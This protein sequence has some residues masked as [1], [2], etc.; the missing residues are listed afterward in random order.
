MAGARV[1]SILAVIGAVL[2]P[3]LTFGLSVVSL[4]LLV[5]PWIV[6]FDVSRA[7]VMSAVV[8]TSL[9]ATFAA[10]MV[11]WLIFKSSP[12]A[13]V[14]AG[15]LILTAGLLL[16]SQAREFWQ[17]AATYALLIG[18]GAALAGGLPARTV[19]IRHY[20]ER[21]GA[22][23]G[24]IMLGVALGGALV[25]IGAGVA[26]ARFGWRHALMGASAIVAVVVLPL[27][28]TLLVS[29]KGEASRVQASS[30]AGASGFTAMM[31]FR[32]PAFWLILA[33]ILPIMM[34]LSAVQS[35][36]V[37][38][39]SD[40]GIDLQHAGYL[41]SIVS[42]GAAIGAV[43]LGSLADRVDLR[44]VYTGAAVVVAVSLLSLVGQ[45]N[46]VVF[47]VAMGL[48]G[49]AAGG[50]APMI[51]VLA[52]R[53]FGLEVFPRVLG[54]IAPFL[55]PAVLGSVLAGRIRDLT[56]GYDLVFMIVAVLMAPGVLAMWR[57]APKAAAAAAP[58]RE[59]VVGVA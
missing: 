52:V 57:L 18:V 37:V 48:L 4:P 16:A 5:A 11:G 10:P 23:S 45:Q 19:A 44:L 21:A 15:A 47:A 1:R 50:A 2:V 49:V 9:G 17:V 30:H 46:F 28:W 34:A 7:A 43:G 6:E 56:G 20:P 42:A 27:A 8:F 22:L 31:A 51:S 55:M 58:A 36:I 32:R 24:L 29:P 25:P 38:I 39:A 59:D 12:R 40:V 33:G 26:L 35:N 54:L 3:A 13:V 41:V 53:H 14:I